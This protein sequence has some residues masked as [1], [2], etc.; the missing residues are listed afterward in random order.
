PP[1]GGGGA[2]LP[3]ASAPGPPPRDLVTTALEFVGHEVS[4]A[5]DGLDALAKVPEVAPDLIVLDVNM[6]HVDG[7]EV[8]RRLRSDGDTTPAIFLTA[9]DAAQDI[10]DGLTAGGDDHLAK[11]FNLKVLIARIDAVLRRVDATEATTGPSGRLRFADIELD[12][13]A[14]RVWRSGDAIA[15]APTEFKLLRYLMLNPDIVLSKDRIATHIWQYDFEGDPNVV[16]TYVSYLRKKLGPPRV[17]QTVRGV[18]YVLRV[19]G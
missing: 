1:R 13:A 14:H 10:V 19:E 9:R 5:V 15:L 2:P 3:R 12:D 8:C 11:P 6:P 4:V 7:I 17:I 16:E 18:G